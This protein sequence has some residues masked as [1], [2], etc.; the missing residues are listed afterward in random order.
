MPNV[1]SC[2]PTSI[3][4]VLKIVPPVYKDTRGFFMEMFHAGRYAELGVSDTF[5][6]DSYSHSCK[7]TLRGLHYQRQ[8]TQAKLI[9]V[10]QGEIFDVAVDIRKGSPTFGQWVGQVLS[11]ENRCQLYI[12][13]GFAHGFCVLS[14]QA[15]VLYKCSE[16]YHPEDDCGLLWSDPVLDIEWPIENPLLSDKDQQLPCLAD[17]SEER[18][19]VYQNM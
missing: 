16:V 13:K 17:I 4:D 19:P 5:V 8:Y 15:D 1:L 9:S 7:G 11:D 14:E 12:P 6:Q 2:E 18:L 10:I 3:P